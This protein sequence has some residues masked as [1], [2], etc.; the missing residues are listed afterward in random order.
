MKGA[1]E[2]TCVGAPGSFNVDVLEAAECVWWRLGVLGV[3]VE[4][5][6][7][8]MDVVK[9]CRCHIICFIYIYK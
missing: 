2:S 7:T 4:V 8:V 1:L 3:S 9:M 5:P 6:G